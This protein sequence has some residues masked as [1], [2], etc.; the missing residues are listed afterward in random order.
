MQTDLDDNIAKGWLIGHTK[1]DPLLPQTPRVCYSFFNCRTLL[2]TSIL[3]AHIS[4]TLFGG[5]VWYAEFLLEI[6]L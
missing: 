4:I 6:D 2:L 1:F 3:H 5:L